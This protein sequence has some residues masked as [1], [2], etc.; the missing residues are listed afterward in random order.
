MEQEEL[1]RMKEEGVEIEDDEYG[2][3]LDDDQFSPNPFYNS[4][5]KGKL[6]E[7]DIKNQNE[8]L[9]K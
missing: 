4:R 1:K 7:A 3:Q 6:A 9:L 5:M 2:Q 8:K